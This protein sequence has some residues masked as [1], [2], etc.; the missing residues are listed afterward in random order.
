M[1]VKK[2]YFI[3]EH[4]HDRI[5]FAMN[6]TTTFKYMHYYYVHLY[7]ITGIIAKKKHKFN[8]PHP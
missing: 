7:V 6:A 3:N 4:R 2:N 8:L 5:T 1:K